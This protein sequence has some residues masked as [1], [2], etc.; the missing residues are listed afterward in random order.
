MCPYSEGLVRGV[1]ILSVMSKGNMLLGHARGKVGDIVFSRVNGQQVTRA[2]A[3]VVKNPKTEKQVIQRIL[4]NTI[5]QAYSRMAEICD[6]SFEGIQ[7][8]QKSMSKFMRENLNALRTKV[9]NHVSETGT[10]EGVYAFAPQGLNV[11]TPNEYVISTGQLPQIVLSKVA[12]ATGAELVIVSEEAIPTYAEIIASL[13]LQ[14]GDQLTFIGQELYTDGRAAFKFARVILDPRE[15]DGSAAELT[16]PFLVGTAINKPSPRNEG[17]DIVFGSTANK[18]TFDL[19]E[20]SQFGAAV[21]VSRQKADG[22]WLR[23]NAN[24]QL[25][26]AIPYALVGAFDMQEAID[27]SYSGGIDLQSD[28]YLNNA[29]RGQK[30]I[31]PSPSPTPGSPR[32]NSV[33]IDGTA[34]DKG[35]TVTKAAGNHTIAATA[36]NIEVGSAAYLFADS[37]DITQGDDITITAANGVS[38]ESGS[39]T[40][41]FELEAYGELT[42]GLAVGG[43]VKEVW[44]VLQASM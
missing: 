35:G 11:F 41:S 24:L 28:L 42:I 20:S 21:I 39:A 10:F 33:S 14:R 44:G 7:V 9:S 27:Y 3:A 23:S 12:A 2:R 16:E 29:T 37:G 8:G 25:D 13:G 15:S 31:A 36:A 18:L 26:P 19:G 32:L 22:S 34:L 43:K 17:A 40:K 30:I 38:I 4:L 6:H 5:I 1:S